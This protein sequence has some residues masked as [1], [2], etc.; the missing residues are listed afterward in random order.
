VAYSIGELADIAVQREQP[1]SALAAIVELR[2]RLDELEALQVENARGQGWSWSEIA[3]PLQV[4]RQAV[5]RKYAKRLE[6][7]RRERGTGGV[8]LSG[9]ARR[10]VVRARREAAAFGHDSVGTDHL[11]LGVLARRRIASALAPIGLTLERALFAVTDGRGVGDGARHRAASPA[12]PI[13]ISEKAG[14]VL[15]QAV[16]EAARLGDESV[17]AEHVL[18]ALLRERDSAARRALDHAGIAPA[19]IEERLRAAVGA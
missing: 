12:G 15:D 19:A 4:S 1:W 14:A 9:E 2:D 8:F 5:H 17:R 11:L 10:C 7:A 18:L 3:Y 16:R 6:A 13:P